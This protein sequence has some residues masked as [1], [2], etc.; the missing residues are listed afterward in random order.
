MNPDQRHDAPPE[1]AL[2]VLGLAAVEVVVA[3]V[4]VRDLALEHV[5]GG[6]EDG[7]ARGDG[8]L[9]VPAASA[10]A[11]L[12]SRAAGIAR[13]AASGKAPCA[14]PKDALGFCKLEL[15]GDGR[16]EPKGEVHV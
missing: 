3:E 12:M 4:L 13:R 10:Q 5:A 6:S 11:L 15:T 8:R 2:G 14:A 1:V 7:I 16:R 9:A